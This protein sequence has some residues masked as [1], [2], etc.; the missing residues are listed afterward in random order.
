MR[1]SMTNL[2]LASVPLLAALP[3]PALAQDH[4]HEAPAVQPAEAP[5]GAAQHDHAA[6]DH[7]QKDMKGM[8]M[9]AV[10]TP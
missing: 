6:M 7:G 9:P 2:L 3:A 5:A 4:Q 8:A 10:T 1:L